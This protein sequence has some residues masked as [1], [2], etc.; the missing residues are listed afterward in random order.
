MAQNKNSSSKSSMGT[1]LLV[2]EI[3]FAVV[4]VLYVVALVDKGPL[5]MTVMSYGLLIVGLVA[6]VTGFI[7]KKWKLGLVD[8]VVGVV[9]FAIYLLLTKLM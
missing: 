2:L 9:G 4:L 3:V 6:A 1:V 7:R 8:L 5:I